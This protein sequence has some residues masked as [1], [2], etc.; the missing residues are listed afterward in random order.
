MK[1]GIILH[2]HTGNTL[3]V[4]ERLKNAFTQAGYPAAVERVTAAEKTPAIHGKITLTNAPDTKSYDVLIFAAPVWA[5]AL[6][7]VMRLYLSSLS[8]LEGKRVGLFVTQG[9][10]FAWLGANKAVGQMKE[11]CE[12]KGAAVL[13]TGVVHWGGSKKE[14]QI[15][16]LIREFKK[17]L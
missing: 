7:P 13:K 11:I 3:L 12:A 1:T 4:G 16:N 6:S 17:A 9:F 5:F 14:D 2:S 10:P 15:E 8:S